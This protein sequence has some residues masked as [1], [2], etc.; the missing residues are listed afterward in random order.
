MRRESCVVVDRGSAS[1]SEI[2]AGA[3]QDN[4]RALI[5]GELTFGKALCNDRW[6]SRMVP[7]CA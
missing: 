4:N 7:L 2:L 1:A 5:V 3:L 6:S